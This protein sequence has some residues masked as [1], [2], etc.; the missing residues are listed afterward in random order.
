MKLSE[1]IY[2]C[3]IET[4]HTPYDLV[5]EQLVAQMEISTCIMESYAKAFDMCMIYQE[6]D[7]DTETK[8]AESKKWYQKLG[9]TAKSVGASIGKFFKA[10]WLWMQQTVTKAVAFGTSQRIILILKRLD[11]LSAEDKAKI[12][13]K[14]PEYIARG[15]QYKGATQL[16]S[17]YDDEGDEVPRM[18]TVTFA[19]TKDIL[20]NVSQEYIDAAKDMSDKIKAEADYS[21]DGLADNFRKISDK[22]QQAA[23]ISY[24]EGRK[25]AYEKDH[26]YSGA[27][28]KEGTG[29]RDMNADQFKA[30][31]EG[32]AKMV[33]SK[34]VK[35]AMKLFKR[36]DLMNKIV[37]ALGDNAE[38][39][40]V[41]EAKKGVKECYNEF[42]K[43]GNMIRYAMNKYVVTTVSELSRCI[44]DAF[45]ALK[46]KAEAEGKTEEAKT[47][48]QEEAQIK[49]EEKKE[50]K[51]AEESSSLNGA[52]GDSETGEGARFE[53]PEQELRRYKNTGNRP[54]DSYYDSSDDNGQMGYDTVTTADKDKGVKLSGGK[55]RGAS[56]LIGPD[57]AY[58]YSQG[59]KD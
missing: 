27:H 2:E 14:I 11:K 32:F 24:K 40:D 23:K 49:A 48:G 29:T 53:S 41:K 42:M 35:D 47:I 56:N 22:M 6:A 45:A 46:K 13:F 17:T 57:D 55:R 54:S 10:L 52:L 51:E 19:L 37:G 18:E 20:G 38:K 3:A 21:L 15:G 4:E 39:K 28:L 59:E 9:D 43:A 58:S 44:K 33:N 8:T 36:K 25:G 7:G 26:W 50:A 5:E 31:L 30:L 12:T 1:F 16:G 34:E